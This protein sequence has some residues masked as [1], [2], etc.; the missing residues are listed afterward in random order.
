MN[1]N[2]Q[3]QAGCRETDDI[4]I[5]GMACLFPGADG[6]AQFW[7]NIVGGV[8]S[9]TDPPADWQPEL[10]FDP[11]GQRDDRVYTA[12]GGY[13]GPQCRFEPT[14]YGVMPNSV[15]GSEPDQFVAL[16][17]TC[18]ALA[19][20]GVPD[21]PINRE[22]TGVIF[23]RGTFVNRGYLTLLYHGF[24]IDQVLEVI[25]RIDP[26]RSEQQLAALKAELRG[27]IPPLN[28]A[29]VPGLCHSV[30]VGRI[31]N[32]LDLH[33][34]T[35][36][37]DG[38]CASSL[39][40]V[41]AGMREL[42][43][44]HCDTVLAGGTQVSTPAVIDLLFCHLGALSRT[45]RIAPFAADADGTLLGQG[46]GVV[47]LKRLGDAVRDGNRIYA[48]LKAIGVAS[49][50][51]AGGLLAPQQAGQQLALERAYERTDVP[52]GSVELIE[53]HGTGI[54]LGDVT[55]MESLRGCFG[56]R[57]KGRP[58]IALG[59]VKSMVSH[60]IPAAGIAALIKTA[61]ALYQRVLPPTLH[62]EEPNPKLELG[63]SPFYLC[64]A[65][66][67][68]LRARC[69]PPR[70]AGVNAFGFGGINAHAIV[71]EHQVADE[72]T[73]RSF[74]RRWPVELVLL[75]APERTDL[76]HR[77]AELPAWTERAQGIEL[78][79]VAAAC[80]RHVQ[81]CRLALCATGLEDLCGKLRHA[82]KLLAQPQRHKIQDRAGI[83]W[84]ET[85]LAA[86]GRLAFL[87]PGEGAQY[88]GML[89]DLCR[90]F[91]QVR[92]QFEL[93]D[94]AFATQGVSPLP[95]RLVFPA[96]EETAQ[97]ES[98]LFGMEAAAEVVATADRALLALLTA[99]GIQA[100]AAVGHSSGEFSAVLAAGAVQLSEDGLV[101]AIADGAACTRRIVESG[102][103]PAAVLTTVG[104]ASLQ[105][106]EQIVAESEGRLCIALDNCPHQL[107]I[108]GD[109]A[110]TAAAV[111]KL[112]RAGGLCQRLPWKRAYHTAAFTPAA[113]VLEDYCAS[114]PIRTPTVQLWSCA[115]AG[116]YPEDPAEIRRLFVRQ[117]CCKVR[118]RETVTAM[119][120]AGVRLFVEVGPRGNLASFI[121][122][123]LTG[124][125]HVAIPLN[126][127][128]KSG[129]AQLCQ[130]LG[131]L[132]AHG[133]S[134]NLQGLYER[135]SPKAL[136][137]SAAPPPAA[138]QAPRLRL[139]L[140]ELK[141]APEAAAQL[142]R[143][144]LVESAPQ[145]GGPTTAM[146]DPAAVPAAGVDAVP[147]ETDDPDPT[148]KAEEARALAEFQRTMRSFLDTQRGVMLGYARRRAGG[149]DA[150]GTEPGAEVT[151][152]PAADEGLPL[153]E[154]LALHEPGQRV[155]TEC[156]L[157]VRKH[158]FLRDHAFAQTLSVS[159]PDLH[160]LV[161]MPL[162]MS[163]EL[164]A[165]AA[166]ILRP[167]SI[168]RP[169]ACALRPVQ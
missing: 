115:A 31:A 32:R 112:T 9:V 22:R 43:A 138:R 19:D 21:I 61:L 128:T 38:A 4:A 148:R 119:H 51:R 64:T 83:F 92:R 116:P 81:P 65:P 66:R 53:A 85:P 99:L 114:L 121:N 68:W 76:A 48:K 125:P 73:L 133:V 50:G 55:E 11:A 158:R 91:P 100:D 157:D 165:E 141:L 28:A 126:V 166:S 98:E 136:D 52:K 107:V 110:A 130:A 13:L 129:V 154:S 93:T 29:T 131:M 36:T 42:R 30:L 94:Q 49:D 101:Q 78:L 10:F 60:L 41:E 151:R 16:Q 47:V 74:E 15:E 90:H 162:A 104:G 169:S 20:A 40:A 3:H 134:M 122:D 18:E 82:A 127:P 164:L 97:A 5:V 37:V 145:R 140:P 25:R 96:P 71:E 142:G 111:D 124:V 163:I 26:D 120:A 168:R 153:V 34:P 63:T 12:R 17:C 143:T 79:D 6:P 105:D 88:V 167:P 57:V 152:D 150:R 23:G 144:C 69:D 7:H 160:G 123:T 1:G 118:F 89:E 39:L 155:I 159:D 54:P 132:A 44:G 46:C 87:F 24:I 14:Q 109:E 35:F 86:E 149:T 146:G 103:V 70:R 113:D 102:R 135:R 106:V 45:G 137:L 72:T 108:A 62:A 161:V 84:Y 59:S 2:D 80:A 156:E 139:E 67:P 27:N 75:S 56:P 58:S 33:G 95:S 117:W 8:D 147:A 77:P